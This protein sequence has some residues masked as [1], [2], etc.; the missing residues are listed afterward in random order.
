MKKI[1]FKKVFSLLKEA[2]D[3]AEQ[4]TAVRKRLEKSLKIN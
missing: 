2:E 4:L 3:L 1:D